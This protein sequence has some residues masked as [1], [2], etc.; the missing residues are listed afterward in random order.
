MK[1]SKVSFAGATLT[2]LRNIL[3]T[4]FTSITEFSAA[5]SLAVLQLSGE[6]AKTWLGGSCPCNVY[7]VLQIDGTA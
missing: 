1:S 5:P 4:Q 2:N 6:L 7:V 3:D